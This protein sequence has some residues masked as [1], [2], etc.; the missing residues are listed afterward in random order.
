MSIS[1]NFGNFITYL[2]V[3]ILRK[4]NLISN[5]LFIR[6]KFSY[7]GIQF[8]A[9]EFHRRYVFVGSSHC[10]NRGQ[11]NKK[12]ILVV[13][14]KFIFDDIVSVFIKLIKFIGKNAYMYFLIKL[15]Y[16]ALLYCITKQFIIHF[17]K[18]RL[19]F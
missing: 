2:A 9:S 6:I 14:Y 18:N 17:G 11:G 8:N 12:Y 4:N 5:I 7:V 15:S 19:Q 3:F 1:N 16:K 10:K 13:F